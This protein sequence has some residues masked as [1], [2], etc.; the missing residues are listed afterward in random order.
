[1]SSILHSF[2]RS[3]SS[4]RLRIALELKGISYDFRAVNLRMAEHKQ[5]SYTA[6]NPQGLVPAFEL[7][8]GTALIQSPAIIEYLEENWPDP[9]LFPSEPDL[10]AKARGMAAIIG[11]DI[12]PINNLRILN[13]L[14]SKFGADE[15]A[16]KDWTGTWI[17]DGFE[18]LE[19]LLPDSVLDGGF[20]FGEQ[21]GVVECY[22][23]PQVFSAHR[24]N[25]DLTGFPKIEALDQRCAALPAFEKAHPANQPAAV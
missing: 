16:I 22:L 24:F 19:A 15:A 10:R 5:P 2:F 9:P 14:K 13:K 20:S 18:A 25:V 8:D 17:K 12:H 3:G 1:M 23:V 7:D 4:H 11:C 21:P 6:L